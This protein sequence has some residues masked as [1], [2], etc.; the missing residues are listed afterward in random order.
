MNAPPKILSFQRAYMR[1][2]ISSV[3][4]FAS[5]GESLFPISSTNGA[6]VS[7]TL[8]GSYKLSLGVLCAFAGD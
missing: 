4:A 7:Y 3:K 8:R 2:L 5:L 1:C 6:V